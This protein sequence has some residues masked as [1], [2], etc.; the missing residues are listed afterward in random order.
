[1]PIY[2]YRCQTC[3]HRFEEFRSLADGDT[4]DC[5]IAL[6]GGTGIKV[7]SPVSRPLGGDTPIHYRNRGAR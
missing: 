1:M 4:C 3:E 5:P 7:P 6:C 2:T